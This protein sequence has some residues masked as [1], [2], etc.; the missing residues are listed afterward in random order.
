MAVDAGEVRAPVFEGTEE[1][2]PG[3]GSD[4]RGGATADDEVRATKTADQFD[5]QALT[6]SVVPAR[7]TGRLVLHSPQAWPFLP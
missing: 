6:F 5:L 4:C 3:C 1:R 7:H 2:L